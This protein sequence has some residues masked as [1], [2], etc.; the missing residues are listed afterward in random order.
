MNALYPTQRSEF[1]CH[2]TSRHW[3]RSLDARRKWLRP[4]DRR[5]ALSKLR[6]QIENAKE[7]PSPEI[8]KSAGGTVQFPQRNN[9]LKETTKHRDQSTAWSRCFSA[10]PLPNVKRYLSE[11]TS[12]KS[13]QLFPS[14]FCMRSA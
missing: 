5:F 11:I 12:P 14:N 1:A 7:M 4:R 3:R 10:K 6:A 8:V 13:T 2:P 9:Q